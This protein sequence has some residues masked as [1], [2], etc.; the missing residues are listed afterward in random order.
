[1]S[2]TIVLLLIIFIIIYIVI[3]KVVIE[4]FELSSSN[5]Q[6][7]AG[8]SPKYNFDTSSHIAKIKIP[9]ITFPKIPSFPNFKPD[10]PNQPNQPNNP[11]QPNQPNK[12]NKP[13]DKTK[14]VNFDN[15]D[16]YK[17]CKKCDITV[18]NDI[19]KYVLKNSIKPCNN[20]DM[21]KYI[22]K[23]DIKPCK[24][25]NKGKKCPQCK[26]P[27][28]CPTCP[29]CPSCPK[30]IKCKQ[31]FDFE[32]KEHPDFDKY[33]LKPQYNSSNNIIGN[34]GNISNLGNTNYSYKKNNL[35]ENKKKEQKNNC[36]I[37]Y[38]GFK[39]IKGKLKPFNSCTHSCSSEFPYAKIN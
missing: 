5:T 8:A 23:K 1:M 16:Y 15:L 9:K 34:S 35:L 13:K 27:P 28:N 32:I 31:I 7:S 22:L 38:D 36:D 6:I 29:K 24:V 33:Q 4:N 21:S 20:L 25:I 17:M 12:P 3:K 10:N 30:P 39:D 19:D 26:K 37:I 2:N 18:N 11:N 14:C